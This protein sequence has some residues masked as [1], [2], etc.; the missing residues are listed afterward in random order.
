MLMRWFA[1]KER[2]FT[3]CKNM[4]VCVR[5]AERNENKMN[6]MSEMNYQKRHNTQLNCSHPGSSNI[7]AI[8]ISP[9]L[10]RT[11]IMFLEADVINQ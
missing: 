4:T 5:L 6:G 3:S 1:C 7:K 9:H 8:F 10:I 11:N 2:F